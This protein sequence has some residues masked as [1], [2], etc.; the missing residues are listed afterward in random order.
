[1]LCVI[2]VGAQKSFNITIDRK[3]NKDNCTIGYL[4]VNNEPIS[5]TLELPWRDNAN[6]ISSIPKG[7]YTGFLRYDKSEGWR[8]QLSDVTGRSGIQLHI[9]NYPSEIEGCILMGMEVNVDG[10]AVFASGKAYANFRKAFYGSDDP[11]KSPDV[12]IVLSVNG[13][14]YSKCGAYVAPGIWKNF[15][16]HNLGAY[17]TGMDPFKPGWQINGG[18]WQWGK[19][20]M[21]ANG[22]VGPGSHQANVD[23]SPNW[24]QGGG[25]SGS[26]TSQRKSINDPCPIG[27]RIP[28]KKEW[29]GVLA[30]NK[31]VPIGNWYKSSTNYSTGIMIGDRLFLPASGGRFNKDSGKLDFR[32]SDGGYWSSSEEGEDI[33]WYL[34]VGRKN[35]EVTD[36]K[37][38]HAICIRCIE[39]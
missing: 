12:K 4:F 5:Y 18:Y 14:N 20:E 34:Y 9:G 33:V 32:G 39:E 10:C 27:Y 37:R 31:I 24:S 28:S 6:F 30:H 38:H 11:V 23:A 26:W 21:A 1:M 15:M 16:C 29:E 13:D 19:K 2:Q 7:T 3:M 17:D 36:A 35:L 8:I 25:P 22:P